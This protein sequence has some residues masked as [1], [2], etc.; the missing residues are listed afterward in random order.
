MHAVIVHSSTLEG[1]GVT[2]AGAGSLAGV[3]SEV[4]AAMNLSRTGFLDSCIH[5]ALLRA[6]KQRCDVLRC[7]EAN[8][9][10]GASSLAFASTISV[11]RASR[12]ARSSGAP[13]ICKVNHRDG[14]THRGC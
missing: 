1:N 7:R 4:T 11:A 5:A 12:T 3:E 13:C 8:D 6:C 10:S 14:C 2:V 9:D